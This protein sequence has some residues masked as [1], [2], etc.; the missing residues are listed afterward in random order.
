MLAG[1]SVP[2]VLF[3]GDTRK[4][5]EWLVKRLDDFHLKWFPAF[6]WQGEAAAYA[7]EDVFW[8]VRETLQREP[9]AGIEMPDAHQFVTFK[10]AEPIAGAA[11]EAEVAPLFAPVPTRAALPFGVSFRYVDGKKYLLVHPPTEIEVPVPAGA[12][13]V[14]I[15]TRMEPRV[16]EQKDFDGAYL[17]LELQRS[18]G[19]RQHVLEEA[20][21]PGGPRRPHVRTQALPENAEGKLVLRT[22]PGPTGSYAFDWLLLEYLR[23][24]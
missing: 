18:D 11:A 10:P 15:A 12:K 6:I 21:P 20:F 16:Y 3:W 24:K 17:T 14:E 13:A 19:T 7:R 23:V 5:T 22:L 9:V 1:E 2:L 4:H 8:R